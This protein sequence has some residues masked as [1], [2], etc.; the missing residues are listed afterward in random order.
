[1]KNEWWSVGTWFL[2]HLWMKSEWYA[3]IMRSSWVITCSY[4]PQHACHPTQHFLIIFRVRQFHSLRSFL[5][6]EL[7]CFYLRGILLLQSPY[8]YFI[9]LRVFL[10]YTVQ[11]CM[12]FYLERERSKKYTRNDWITKTKQ[13]LIEIS[14]YFNPTVSRS[15]QTLSLIPVRVVF[16]PVV[17][18]KKN[19]MKNNIFT[20][21]TKQK[22]IE[23]LC[24]VNV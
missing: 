17:Q 3:L 11:P 16:S 24:Y 9:L 6:F 13:K 14:R 18:R 2:R 19:D 22:P 8:I 5:I 4:R 21:K 7:L 20:T 12:S 23:I 15:S 10:Y 1:M